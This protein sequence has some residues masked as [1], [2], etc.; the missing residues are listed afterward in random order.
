MKNISSRHVPVRLILCG[1]LIDAAHT[2]DHIRIHD[3][4]DD[5][6]NNE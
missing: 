5:N 1:Y 2:P 4:D 6:N 3:D